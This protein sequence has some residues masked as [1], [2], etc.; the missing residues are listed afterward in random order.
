MDGRWLCRLIVAGMVVVSS[1]GGGDGSGVDLS[2][3]DTALVEAM[4]SEEGFFGSA[5]ED[6]GIDTRCVAEKMVVAMGGASGAESRYGLTIDDL[7]GNGE[8]FSP[9]D[10]E[11][12][13]EASFG[14]GAEDAEVIAVSLANLP[15]STEQLD[16]VGNNVDVDRYK[17]LRVLELSGQQ[18]A[19]AALEDEVFA[20]ASATCD[21]S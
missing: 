1:C 21:L 19:A 20:E 8:P 9:D 2:A 17:E 14:C 5:W 16:C 13:V 7:F 4:V 10:A 15:L 11:G 6:A 18:Q 3:E 12:V